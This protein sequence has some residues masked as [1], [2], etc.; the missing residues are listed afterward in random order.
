MGFSHNVNIGT[1]PVENTLATIQEVGI[2]G[3]PMDED[4]NS[5]P[6]LIV[7]CPFRDNSLRL[8]SVSAQL[9]KLSN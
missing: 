5:S 3:S 2:D 6:A 8:V 9:L 7:A 4:E 1:T